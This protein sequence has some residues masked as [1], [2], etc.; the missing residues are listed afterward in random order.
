MTTA[1]EIEKREK[2]RAY[3]KE[4]KLK[5]RDRIAA[6]QREYS[7]KSE[8]KQ[9]KIEYDKTYHTK[10]KQIKNK[11]SNDY[12][13]NNKYYCNKR[14]N[15]NHRFKRYN[16]TSEQYELFKAEQDNKCAICEVD[17]PNGKGDFHIDHCHKTGVIRGLLCMKCNVGLGLLGDNLKN[18]ERAYIYMLKATNDNPP[19][20]EE[21]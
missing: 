9:R 13:H 17:I 16:I 14:N 4:Y 6:R 15:D 5:N 3:D 19:P 11:R 7:N 2:K 20:T 21:P 1:S 8:N 10:N 18:L 12:Y